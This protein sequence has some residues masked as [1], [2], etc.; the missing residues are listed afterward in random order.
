MKCN[1]VPVIYNSMHVFYLEKDTL[2]LNMGNRYQKCLNGLLT[3][4][5]NEKQKVQY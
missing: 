3:Q 2:H 5:N 4:S 1:V